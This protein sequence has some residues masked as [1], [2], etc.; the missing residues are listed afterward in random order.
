MVTT[1]QLL[2]PLKTRTESRT[3]DLPKNHENTRNTPYKDE[4]R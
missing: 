1:T 2:K 4:A 3:S